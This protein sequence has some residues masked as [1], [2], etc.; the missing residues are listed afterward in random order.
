MK[1]KLT[2][3]RA[4]RHKCIDCCAGQ[5][6]EVKLCTAESCPLYAYRMGKLPDPLPEY[7]DGRPEPTEED[8]ERW[9]KFGQEMR[10]KQLGN[11]SKDA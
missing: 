9:K 4:I 7:D 3:L 6:Y 2:P 1:R 8:R 5:V 11:A 10:A